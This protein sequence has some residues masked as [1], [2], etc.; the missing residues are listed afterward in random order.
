MSYRLADVY[1]LL[2]SWHWLGIAINLS[3][4][5]GL[6]QLSSY[7]IKSR[8]M[9]HSLLIRIWWCIHCREAWLSIAYGRPMRIHPNDV[10]TS[11][12]VHEDSE[13]CNSGYDNGIHQYY[14]PEEHDGIFNIWRCLVKL[15]VALAKAILAGYSTVTDSSPQVERRNQ[16]EQEI[17]MA[18]SELPSKSL[19]SRIMMIHTI[20]LRLYHQ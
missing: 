6:H 3:F 20:Q 13:D 8:R 9:S 11:L 4:I 15:T 7:N 10:N 2:G 19:D 12:P 5:I 18:L 1:E 16:I 14:S 17:N